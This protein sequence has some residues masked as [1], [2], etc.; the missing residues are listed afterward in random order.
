[1]VAV[2]P[3]CLTLYVRSHGQVKTFVGKVSGTIELAQ[4][5]HM[6]LAGVHTGPCQVN[7]VATASMDMG[8][9]FYNT[10]P[11]GSWLYF[12]GALQVLPCALDPD[13]PL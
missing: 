8:D 3:R 11:Q 6:L 12:T 7:G 5:L 2:L 9:F 10:L 13:H 1:M 4:Q